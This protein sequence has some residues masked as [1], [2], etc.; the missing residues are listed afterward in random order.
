MKH[1]CCAAVAIW[2]KEVI[3]RNN[4]TLTE[5]QIPEKKKTN[6]QQQTKKQQQP[7]I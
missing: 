1:E 4:I 5:Q 7:G 6:K 3:K 2:C